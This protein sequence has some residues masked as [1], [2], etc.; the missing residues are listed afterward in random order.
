MARNLR[1]PLKT[2]FMTQ[3]RHVK[4]GVL[5]ISGAKLIKMGYARC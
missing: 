5:R 1:K 3:A 2:W 4:Q